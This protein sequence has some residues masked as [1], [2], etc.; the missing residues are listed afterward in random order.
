VTADSELFLRCLDQAIAEMLEFA[1][2]AAP[3]TA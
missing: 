2:R 3:P 1:E